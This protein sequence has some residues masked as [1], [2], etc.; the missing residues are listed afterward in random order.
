M[1]DLNLI[2]N[3]PEKVTTALLKRMDSVDLTEI[4]KLDQRR[5]ALIATVEAL[6]AQRRELARA[7]GRMRSEGGN[8][9]DIESGAVVV[10]QGIAHHD[11]ELADIDRQLHDLLSKL[12]NIPDDRVPAGGKENNR[13]VRVRGSKPVE[14][15]AQQDHVALSKRLGLVDYER[16]TKLAGSGFW[17][18]TGVGAALEWAL[19]DFFCQQHFRDGYQFLLPPHLLDYESGFAAGQFPKFEEDVFHLSSRN[20]DRKRFLLPTAETAIVNFYRNEILTEAQLPIK[21]FAYTPCYR[22]EAGSHRPEERGTVRGHQFNKVEMFQFV[23]PEHAE[24]AIEELIQRAESLM[25]AL[26][27]HYRT[28]LLAARDTSSAMALT[29]DVEVWIPSMNAYKEVSSASWARDYQARRANIR[30]RRRGSKQTEFVHTLNASGLATSRLLPAILEQCQQSDGSV[31][32]PAP[33]R[34][35]L[36]RD[37][38]EPSR[39]GGH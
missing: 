37:A 3:E 5:R 25:N 7:S 26:G 29:Y 4:L 19:L 13:V 15:R 18:Y 17:I 36:G 16:G 20:G 30:F 11:G 31:V 2:R 23:A 6:R 33:L 1:L 22:R 12:P 35:W 32:V 10:N 27:L 28:S 39:T 24:A 8:P 38:I 34:N 9:A 14:L 21:C